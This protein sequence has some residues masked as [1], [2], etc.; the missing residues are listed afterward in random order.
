VGKSQQFFIAAAFIVLGA[1]VVARPGLGETVGPQIGSPA[2]EERLSA[3]TEVVDYGS[4]MELSASYIVDG[5]ELAGQPDAAHSAIWDLVRAIVPAATI[6]ERIV[7]F[8]VTTDGVEQTLAMVHRS[9]RVE[10]GWI[11]SIDSAD[12]ADGQRLTET[13]IHE[14]AHV[15]TLNRGEVD[16]GVPASACGDL[17]LSVGCVVPNSIMGRYAQ[18]FWNGGDTPVDA[19]PAA[20]V[21]GYASSSAHE[22]LAE[23]FMAWALNLSVEQSPAIQEKFGF[24]EAEPVLVDAK[25][26]LQQQLTSG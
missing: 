15:L 16:F 23:S 26:E 8:N 21:T 14:L 1:L 9:G 11:L 6:D 13:L 18:R 2:T 7:Q 22:D 12:I 25:T 17:A 20:F 10:T 19:R 24:F 4:Q 5:T 3:N